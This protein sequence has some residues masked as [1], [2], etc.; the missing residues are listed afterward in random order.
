MLSLVVSALSFLASSL[1]WSSLTSESK[2]RRNQNCLVFE[3]SH[4]ADVDNLKQT[5]K[6][7]D[8]TRPDEWDNTI[9]KFVARN[10]PKQYEEAKIDAAPEY[11]DEEGIGLPEP[12]PEIPAYRDYNYILRG[13]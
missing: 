10:V 7:L 13:N 2:D 9:I 5:F 4:K 6:F 1:L 12:D 8:R 3:G 11:C